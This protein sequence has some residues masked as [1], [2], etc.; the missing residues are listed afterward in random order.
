MK[1]FLP[2]IL[3]F[4]AFFFVVLLIQLWLFDYSGWKIPETV[5][6][7]NL[8]TSGLLIVG[9]LMVI[10]LNAGKEFLKISPSSSVAKLTLAGALIA[11]FSEFAFQ[12]VRAFTYDSDRFYHFLIGTL[13]TTACYT[14]IAF[15][16]SFQLKTKKT[17]MLIFYILVLITI[18]NIMLYFF[19]DMFKPFV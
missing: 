15:F 10:L 1:Q 17:G 16:E 4:A 6:N 11:F 13:S 7:T 5:P 14:I 19:P 2:T 8:R 9:A 3:K 18:G 12:I